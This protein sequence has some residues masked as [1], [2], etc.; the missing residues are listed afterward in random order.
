MAP[1]E[2][3]VMIEGSKNLQVP[4]AAERGDLKVR[5]EYADATEGLGTVPPPGSLKGMAKSGVD[6]LAGSR[7]QVLVDKLGER[8]AFERG[9]TRLYD[10]LLVKC[11]AA[12]PA[13]PA[14][15]VEALRRFPDQEVQHF[16]L[17]ADALESLGADPTAQ[18]PCADPVG[19]Q[20][21]GLV[22][23]MNDPRTSI[24]QSLNVMMDT[25]LID[26]AGWEMLIGLARS[27][28][29]GRIADDFE[30]AARQEAQHLVHIRELVERLTSQDASMTG[31]AGA[32]GGS[33]VP[34]VA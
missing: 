9:G 7:P 22:Q 23:A 1:V 12:S 6:M 19:V 8:L 5:R 11:R 32:A 3:V 25:E 24:V 33:G 20:S 15:D 26:N 31:M 2:A 29:H 34:P 30:V 14:E 21:M 18:T 28:G 13:L 10:T 27:L 16:M 4:A 17:V